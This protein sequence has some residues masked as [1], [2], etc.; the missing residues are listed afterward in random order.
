MANEN[1]NKNR[2][3]TKRQIA[4]EKVIKRPKEAFSGKGG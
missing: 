1:A 2:V 3:P 4:A